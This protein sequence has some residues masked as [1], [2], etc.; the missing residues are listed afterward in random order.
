MYRG[1]TGDPI[2]VEQPIQKNEVPEVDKLQHEHKV[3]IVE[4]IELEVDGIEQSNISGDAKQIYDNII[5]NLHDESNI[6]TE[7]PDEDPG[8]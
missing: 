4:T 5:S 2:P 6:K 7:S 3:K 8:K 1:N